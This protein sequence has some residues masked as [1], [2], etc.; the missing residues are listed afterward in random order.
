MI[1]QF[2]TDRAHC[3]NRLRSF[4]L[5]SDGAHD[6]EK[7]KEDERNSDSIRSQQVMDMY[8]D[9]N[10]HSDILKQ[11]AVLQDRKNRD[12]ER[13]QL[14]EVIRGLKPADVVLKNVR[15]VNV[16]TGQILQGDLALWQDRIAGIGSY[17]GKTEIDLNGKMI[18]P[19]LIDA[20]FHIESTMATP[21]GLSGLLL[22]HGVTTVIADPHEIV[23]AAGSDGFDF[24]IEDA[25]RA[26]TDYFFMAPSSVPSCDFEVNG[27]GDFDAEQIS[28]YLQEKR[29]LGLAE[30]MRMQ[31][32][33]E[34]AESMNRKL[35]LFSGRPIDGHAPGLS[36]KDLQAYRAAGIGNDHEASSC[37]EAIERLQNGFHLLIRQ[38][39]GARNLQDILP[40]LI[41]QNIQLNRCSFCTDDMHV[42]DIASAGSIDQDIRLSIRMSCDPV[43]ALRMGTINTSEHFGLRDRGAI[44]PGYLADFLVI[45]SLENFE[46]ESVWKN[47][48]QVIPASGKPAFVSPEIPAS[49]RSSVRMPQ[50][51]PEDFRWSE[52]RIDGI[53][54]VCDQLYTKKIQADLRQEK[55]PSA[56]NN[57]A[58]AI[59]RYGK[60]GEFAFCALKGYGIRNGAIAMS[61]AHDSHNVVAAADNTEDL[62]LALE[63]MNRIQGGI[64]LTENGKVVETLPMEAAGLM[65]ALDADQIIQTVSRIKEKIWSMGVSRNIDPFAPLSFIS[66]PVIPEIRLTIQG[67][68]DVNEQRFLTH[69]RAKQKTQDILKQGEADS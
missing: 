34:G 25:G 32:V 57:I 30:V 28:R 29:V 60:T 47:G 39:S 22:R 45:D 43:D 51:E 59:E 62:L 31:D 15:I 63:E 42:E 65:S 7:D 10:S 49:L 11:E 27:A 50:L 21:S 40:G 13:K 18:V 4:F 16:F 26:L 19:G 64:V 14:L 69:S 58:A 12:F 68:Y 66:L 9:M 37:D 46:I 1:W 55:F 48:K 36:G 23:N 24:M 41:E 5:N 2:L 33:L 44:A 20:H 38:G 35:E 54:L 61:Y 6:K 17:Q 67:L 56:A 3:L 53:E 8:I 52:D